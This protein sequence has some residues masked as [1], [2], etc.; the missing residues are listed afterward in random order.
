MAY[1]Y[2]RDTDL[3]FP[4]VAHHMIGSLAGKVDTFIDNPYISRRH[5]SIEWNGHQWQIKDLS[6]NGTWVNGKR[7][8]S[9]D[10]CPLAVGD[11][12]QLAGEEGVVLTVESVAPPCDLLVPVQ[13]FT[14]DDLSAAIELNSVNLIPNEQHPEWYVEQDSKTGQW[15]AQRIISP[16]APQA[17]SH[18]D[19]IECRAGSW[20]LFCARDYAPT[21]EKRS[22]DVCISE[23]YLKFDV[24]LDEETTDL[25]VI[26][27]DANHNLGIR[28]HNYLLLLLARHRVEDMARGLSSCNQ[29]W[30][31][32]ELLVRELG[33]EPG[34]LNIQ[35]YRARQ[36][37]SK[38]MPQVNNEKFVER[39]GTTLRLGCIQFSIVKGG[40]VEYQHLDGKTRPITLPR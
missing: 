30:V 20:Q 9:G 26:T 24:S 7:L 34:H 16:Q 10:Y 37:L 32:N 1:L 15:Q 36:Q 25:D 21:I 35:I 17:L 2:R 40:N 12:V 38:M 29:G 27:G 8:T 3:R 5:L 18:G 33:L 11:V 31:P 23:S 22:Q 19:I 28:A 39:R 4:V 13:P 14:K 6:R